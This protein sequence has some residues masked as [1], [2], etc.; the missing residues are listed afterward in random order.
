MKEEFVNFINS[1]MKANPKITEE[2]LTDNIKA[3]LEILQSQEVKPVLTDGGRVV[4]DYMKKSNENSFKA[5]DIA[6]GLFISS[7]SVSG[8]LRKLVNDGF[9]EKINN[10]PVIYTLTEKGKNFIID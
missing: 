3:Y 6:E 8:S 2:L 1:L 9:V 5:K 4:L 10:D 7:R